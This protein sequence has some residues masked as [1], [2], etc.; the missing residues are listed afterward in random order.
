MVRYASLVVI[1]HLLVINKC[2]SQ[3]EMYTGTG[4][5]PNALITVRCINVLRC[6]RYKNIIV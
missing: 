5:F 6:T 3:S 4:G 1:G 2:C